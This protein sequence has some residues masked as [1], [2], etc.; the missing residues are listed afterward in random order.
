MKYVAFL[1]T[2]TILP[3][4]KRNIYWEL[5]IWTIVQ[6]FLELELLIA[7]Y[8]NYSEYLSF[9]VLQEPARILI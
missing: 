1:A 3:F 2:I 4:Y 9:W 5:L 8:G 6:T 7:M